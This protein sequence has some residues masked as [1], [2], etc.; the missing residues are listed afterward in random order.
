MWVCQLSQTAVVR[1]KRSI[2]HVGSHH[3][4]SFGFVVDKL[5]KEAAAIS[6]LPV[7]NTSMLANPSV[8]VYEEVRKNSCWLKAI[9]NNCVSRSLLAHITH[10]TL[11][12]PFSH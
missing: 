6:P 10:A 9:C 7:E 1:E 3:P 8:H 5:L 4:Q 11:P 12:S 2:R